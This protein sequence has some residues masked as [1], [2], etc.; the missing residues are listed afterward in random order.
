MA[1]KRKPPVPRTRADYLAQALAVEGGHLFIGGGGWFLH[2]APGATLR[3]YD[4]AIMKARCAE[5]GLPVIDILQGHHKLPIRLPSVNLLVAV[6]RP[7]D[8]QPWATSSYAPLATVAAVYRDAGAEVINAPVR[9]RW[10][11]FSRTERR[12]P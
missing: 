1:G 2:Y 6:G 8:R 11:S 12:A 10:T 4:L 7:P 3:G 9:P 5:A